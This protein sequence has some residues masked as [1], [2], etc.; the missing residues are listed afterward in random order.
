MHPPS[1]VARAKAQ[2]IH[3]FDIREELVDL[4]VSFSTRKRYRARTEF[5]SGMNAFYLPLVG[6]SAAPSRASAKER[7]VGGAL[8]NLARSIPDAV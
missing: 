3:D 4:S 5:D 6:R 7:R 1:V 2:R 8:P